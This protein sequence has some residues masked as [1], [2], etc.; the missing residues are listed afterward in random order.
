[1]PKSAN[2]LP[3][4]TSQVSPYLIV[5]DAAKAIDYY[6]KVFGAR[7][8]IRVDSPGNKVG[9]AELKIG[10]SSIMI[11][12]E[13]P[14]MNLQGPGFF[15]GTPVQIHLYVED[16]DAVAKRAV[17]AGGKLEKP[18]EDMFYGDRGGRLTDPFGHDWWISTHKV[19]LSK[20]EL[21]K[22]AREMQLEMQPTS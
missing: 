18:L 12:D 13:F 5:R 21:Q 1:M 8:V 19:D 15:G 17:D 3:T 22:R 10:S 7:E 20:E 4:E 16:V 14:D 11:T 2:W 6:K 9:H